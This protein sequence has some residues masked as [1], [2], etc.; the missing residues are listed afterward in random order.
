MSSEDSF[1]PE[2]LAAMR[3]SYVAGGLAEA[4]LAPT[5]LEQLLVWIAEAARHEVLEPNAMIVATAGA[6][7]TPSARTVLLKNLDERGLVF[8]TNYDSRK[9]RQLT[10][11]PRA[12]VLFPWHQ[13]QR[14]VHVEGA[15]ERLGATDADAYWASRPRGSQIG[16]LASPQSQVVGSRRELEDAAGELT[17]R[18]DNQ[19]VPRPEHWGGFRV[20][21]ERVEFWQGRLDRL[22]DRLRFRRDGERWVVERLAP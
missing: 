8:F 22:H 15:V 4:D 12:A 16:A 19:D 18:Y 10:E 20:V 3:R 5:W 14:Q 17:S 6:D 11:N 9:G 13:L 7:G 2:Q 1:V 21:P